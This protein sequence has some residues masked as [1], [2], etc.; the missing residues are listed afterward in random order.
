MKILKI[1]TERHVHS[2]IQGQLDS[3]DAL[4]GAYRGNGQI[5]GRDQMTVSLEHRIE[6]YVFAPAID[7]FKPEVQNERIRRQIR[8]IKQD[9]LS[10][11]KFEFIG[12]DLSEPDGCICLNSSSLIL[13]TTYLQIQGPIRCGDC[14]RPVPL[15]RLPRFKGENFQEVNCWDADYKSCDS[16][17]MNSLTGERFGYGEISKIDS[18]LSERGRS[19]CKDLERCTGK[20]V[21]Y[22]LHRYYGRSKAAE[23]ARRCPS[24]RRE[25]RLSERW[26]LF[27]FKCDGC[28]IVSNI[29]SSAA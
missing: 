1:V 27:D 18:S 28:R 20:A 25:W 29:S 22:Y 11:P 12:D 2:D 24:C 5:L 4:L 7:A 13:F 16:L 6:A 19:I 21:Y 15:Y 8:E 3:F 10:E 9:G 17:F 26:H 23:A 14:F